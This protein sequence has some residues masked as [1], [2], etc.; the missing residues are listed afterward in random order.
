[1]SIVHAIQE[2]GHE[3]TTIEK[4]Q[5]GISDTNCTTYKNSNGTSENS[6]HNDCNNISVDDSVYANELSSSSSSS[7]NEFPSSSEL[8]NF[9]N[10]V[11]KQVKADLSAEDELLREINLQLPSHDSYSKDFIPNGISSSIVNH[12]AYKTLIEDLAGFKEQA[13][14]LQL[15]ISR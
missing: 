10:K 11:E 15:E 1:M 14:R 7:A 5:N 9:P 4:L 12:P 3:P 13:S 6:L 2:E 8:E